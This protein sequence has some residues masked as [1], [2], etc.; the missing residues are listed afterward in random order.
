MADDLKKNERVRPDQPEQSWRDE[1]G[2]QEKT[3]CRKSRMKP[4]LDPLQ[5]KLTVGQLIS[6]KRR[7]LNWSQEELSWNSGISRSEVGRIE[8]DEC[9]PKVS[10]IE[11]LESALGMELFDLFMQQK[12]ERAREK[13]TEKKPAI[14]ASTLGKFGRDLAGTGISREEVKDVLDEALKSAESRLSKEK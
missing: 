14:P 5:V 4:E 6:R 12:R 2:G 8:R 11:G 10:S 3:S 1:H 13:R 7:E 9:D